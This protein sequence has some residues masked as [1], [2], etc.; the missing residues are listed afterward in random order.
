MAAAQQ[1][2]AHTHKL[3]HAKVHTRAITSAIDGGK[4]DQRSLLRR[5]VGRPRA[6]L[7]VS[8]TCI[9]R[10][11]LATHVNT[12]FAR[13]EE[14][15]SKWPRSAADGTRLECQRCVVHIGSLFRKHIVGFVITVIVVSLSQL[16]FCAA[17]WKHR[18]AD[19]VHQICCIS[20]V[21]FRSSIIVRETKL[22]FEH[23]L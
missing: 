21:S 23:H 19:A 14:N 7:R 11:L 8:R 3:A 1:K 5:L 2:Q 10:V 4:S 18:L 12:V 9:G 6:E 20:Y 13:G 16:N 17:D 22:S 15:G